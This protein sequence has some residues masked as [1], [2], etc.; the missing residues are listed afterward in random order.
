M[1][2]GREGV[3]ART[4]GFGGCPGEDTPVVM[5]APV[6]TVPVRVKVRGWQASLHLWRLR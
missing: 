1:T 4:L 6:G 2:D 3:R 5:L